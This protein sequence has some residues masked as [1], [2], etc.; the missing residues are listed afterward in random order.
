MRASGWYFSL[1]AASLWAAFTLTSCQGQK[2]KSTSRQAPSD[3]S[4]Q[5]GGLFRMNVASE[6]RSIFPHNI[7]DNS[8]A[9]I[10]N[11]VYEGLLRINP[12]TKQIEPCLANSYTVSPDG[13]TYTF[14]LREDV[15]FHDDKIFED[16]KGRNMTARDV[17]FCFQQLCRPSPHNQLYSFLVDLIKGGSAYYEAANTPAQLEGVRVIDEY[18]LALELEYPA[19]TF[20]SVLTHPC[21]WIFPKELLKYGDDMDFWCI[22]TGPFMART[23]KMNEVLILERNKNYWG[24]DDEGFRLPYLDAVRCNFIANEAKE[25]DQFLLGNLDLL[26]R[27]PNYSVEKLKRESLETAETANYNL[28]TIPGLRT[29]YYGFQHRR[30]LFK[31]LKVRQALNYAVDKVFIV[32]SILQGY[33]TP[34][35]HGFVPKAMPNYN[36]ADISGYA[37]D[38]DLARKLFAEAGY[39]DG[40]GFPV[41]TL[42]LDYGN[43]K[44][45]EVAEAVQKMLVDNLNITLE[46]SV[47]D[48]DMHYDRI[49][50]RGVDFWRDGWI[51]DYADPENFLRLFYGKLVPADSVRSSFLNTIRFQDEQFDT[52]FE[53]SLRQQNVAERNEFYQS[54]DQLLMN[55]AAVLPLYHEEWI[56][57][58][59]KR[60]QNLS[61]SGLGILSLREV[62]FDKDWERTAVEGKS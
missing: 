7:V 32:D 61:V 51:A 43:K 24:R 4:A 23:I 59:N 19:A 36:S 29:E 14:E 28:M 10:M 52:Y 3:S 55:Q 15:Y 26:M 58:I 39:P 46:L 34:A 35:I 45:I 11:Q 44:T 8:A 50:L 40:A 60:V 27:V 17:A 41:L 18:T 53:K 42:Q 5:V 56:W 13:A 33:G 25:L 20:T 54:A 48:R 16:G 38:P 2:E 49:E 12:Q 21:T 9:N 62:Y 1:F 37:Y 31:D 30:D 22:G 57:L 47:V 6:T